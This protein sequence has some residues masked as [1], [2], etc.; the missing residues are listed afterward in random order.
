MLRQIR[1]RLRT[2]LSYVGLDV[3]IASNMMG[4]DSLQDI[5]KLHLGGKFRTVIDIGANV[6]QSALRFHKAFPE[7]AI[8]SFEPVSLSYHSGRENTLTFPLIT[9]HQLAVGNANKSIVFYSQGTSQMNSISNSAAAQF[10]HVGERNEVEM[11]CF[12]DFYIAKK[13]NHVDLLK[14]DTE[15][16]DLDVLE[17]ASA[18]LAGRHVSFVLCEVGFQQA[19]KSHSFFPSIA[20]YLEKFGYRLVGFYGI[21]DIIHFQ[22]HG[23]TYADALFTIPHS[24]V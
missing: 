19:D 21:S 11:V 10:T 6:G 15:G 3:R 14:T 22:K 1:H 20:D 9:W 17:G 23:G 16:W 8:H 18:T 5:K 7:A 24:H 2:C 4:F 13:L 12:D